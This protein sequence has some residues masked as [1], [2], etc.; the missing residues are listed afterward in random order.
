MKRLLTLTLA[1][2]AL[3]LPATALADA[4]VNTHMGINTSSRA[5]TGSCATRKLSLTRQL[6]LRCDGATGYAV[7]R[8]DFELP[9]SWS[10]SAK[11]HVDAIGNPAVSLVKLDDCHVRVIVRTSGPSWVLVTSV[12]V[13]YYS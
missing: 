5:A 13:G 4:C 11:A 10:G 6:V 7:A 8:Y 3:A 2:L 12:S 9:N 1:G